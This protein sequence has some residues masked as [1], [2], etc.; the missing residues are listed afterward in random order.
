MSK[1]LIG[2]YFSRWA[3]LDNFTQMEHYARSRYPECGYRILFH[4]QHGQMSLS[5]ETADQLEDLGHDQWRKA[6]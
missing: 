5:C 4:Q 2:C 1:F 6:Q 3:R